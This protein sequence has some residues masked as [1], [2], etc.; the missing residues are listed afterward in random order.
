MQTNIFSLIEELVAMSGSS[1]SFETLDSE[2]TI[3]NS[4]IPRLKSELEELKLSINDDKYFD[5]SQE[6][7]DRNIE[8]SVSKK[9]SKLEKEYDDLKE[10]TDKLEKEEQKYFET[11][12]SLKQKIIK[13]KKNLSLVDERITNSE[14]DETQTLYK[15]LFE[16]EES[17]ILELQKELELKNETLTKLNNEI[18]EL[19]GL[20][21][22]TKKL[23]EQAMARLI[24]VRKSLSNKKSYIDENL[25]HKDNEQLKELSTKIEE[26]ENKKTSILNDANF[27]SNEVKELIISKDNEKALEKLSE[28]VISVK[29][30]PYMEISDRNALNEELGK[31]EEQQ[32]DFL[33]AIE[34]KNYYGDD[35]EFIDNR[36]KYLETFNKTQNDEI[37][38][39]KEEI[40]RI[41]SELVLTVANE[42]KIAENKADELE[43]AINEASNMLSE[44]NKTSLINASL[45]A[46]I[47]RKTH[48]LK[49]INDIIQKYINELNLLIEKSSSLENVMIKKINENITA[50]IKECKELNKLKLMSTKSKDTIE[51]ELDKKQVK[52]LAEEIKKLKHRLSFVKN[53]DEIYDEIE[54]ILTSGTEATPVTEKTPDIV[55]SSNFETPEVIYAAN[56]EKIIEPVLED[57]KLDTIYTKEET[58]QFPL[59]ESIDEPLNPEL[60]TNVKTKED[61]EQE[62]IL[63]EL[64]DTAY[65]SLDDFLK[66]F[67]DQKEE[68]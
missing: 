65:F 39:L 46:T 62:Y 32:R 47:T 29:Q 58:E 9:L 11:I 34:A 12:D 8:I 51:Q 67:D 68:A 15:S 20:T 10:K 44:D 17:K 49:I 22:K 54:M 3:I 23:I 2:L 33:A 57:R 21:Q 48:E 35:V 1:N 7:L 25:K 13:T 55:E 59:F 50:N 63:S 28:L 41:D 31:L 14:N 30:E 56:D 5:A 61:D 60:S 40:K 45:K 42:L 43:K 19:N 66:G 16:E 6:I 27:I 18:N 26:L 52:V 36:I 38:K 53:P 64:E 24:E 4:E 37:K